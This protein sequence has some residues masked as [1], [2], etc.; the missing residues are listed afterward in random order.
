[1]MC[2]FVTADFLSKYLDKPLTILKGICL[3]EHTGTVWACMR[4]V[5]AQMGWWRWGQSHCYWIHATI[6]ENQWYWQVFTVPTQTSLLCGPAPCLR[7]RPVDRCLLR[8][9]RIPE[10]F[11]QSSRMRWSSKNHGRRRWGWSQLT[12]SELRVLVGTAAWGMWVNQA[13]RSPDK[14]RIIQVCVVCPGVWPLY[15]AL[16]IGN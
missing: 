1:M 10:L 4:L 6:T 12:D 8:N 15:S 13:A 11:F 5:M 16:G 2:S 9:R 3:S 7:R 14:I